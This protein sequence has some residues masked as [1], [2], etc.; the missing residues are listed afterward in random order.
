MLVLKL[1]NLLSYKQYFADIAAQHVSIQ[2]YKWGDKRDVMN[3]NASDATH[4]Y[5]WAY[6]YQE[7]NFNDSFSDNITKEKEATVAYL[8]VR[9]S[10]LFA[11]ED[12]QYERCEALMDEII[13]RILRDKK[14]AQVGDD[15]VMIATKVTFKTTPVEM[16]IGSTSWL[17]YELKMTFIDNAGLE[18]DKEKWNDTK[19]V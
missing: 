19:T 9:D 1:T 14:G 4:N 3:D 5:L 18:F 17:G 11:D 7:T 10:Q 12:A 2:G 6:P 8:E 16:K 13:A 15:W